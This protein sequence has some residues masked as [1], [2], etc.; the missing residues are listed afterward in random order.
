VHQLRVQFVAVEQ[1]VPELHNTVAQLHIKLLEVQL[2]AQEAAEV[3]LEDK[4]EKAAE[5][6]PSAQHRSAAMGR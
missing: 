2:V 5:C 1:H 6:P 3:S 4:L